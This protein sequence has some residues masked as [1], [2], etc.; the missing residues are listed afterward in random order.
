MSQD[1]R[2]PDT[3]TSSDSSLTDIQPEKAASVAEDQPCQGK[4]AVPQ[5]EKGDVMGDVEDDWALDPENARNWSIGK[6]WATVAI[7]RSFFLAA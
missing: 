5:G 1:E 6:K 3:G 4:S 7:V 2:C